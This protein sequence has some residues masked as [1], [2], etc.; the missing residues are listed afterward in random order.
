MTINSRVR[1]CELAPDEVYSKMYLESH[2]NT[3]TS[4]LRGKRCRN[5]ESFFNEVSASFQFPAYFGE[6]WAAFD[7]CIQ[8]LEWISFTRIFVLF[9]DFSQAFSEPQNLQKLMQ[10][11]VVEYWNRAIKYWE[12]Q[13]II[14]EVWINN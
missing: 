10:K 13:G 11:Q 6:N 2:S 1:V 8:D 5:E 14:M 3:Y 4:Y 9:D 12:S 7:E